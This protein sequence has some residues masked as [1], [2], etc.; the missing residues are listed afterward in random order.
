MSS[1]AF[2]LDSRTL[3]SCSDDKTVK[4]WDFKSDSD[5]NMGHSHFVYAVVFSPD[6]KILASSSVDKTVRLW[7]V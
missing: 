6:S 5:T 3:A 1:V 4:L 2:S 7:D